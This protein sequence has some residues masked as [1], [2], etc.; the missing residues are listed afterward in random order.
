MRILPFNIFCS[1][2]RGTFFTRTFAAGSHSFYDVLVSGTL[3]LK[4]HVALRTDKYCARHR[5]V[6]SSKALK[7]TSQTRYD[8]NTMRFFVL[9]RVSYA[10][11][12]NRLPT[13]VSPQLRKTALIREG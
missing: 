3:R 9:P 11:Q 2:H 5:Y 4:V 13:V 8:T 1:P 6:F 12:V 7:Q 10:L